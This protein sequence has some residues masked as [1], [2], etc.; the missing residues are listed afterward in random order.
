M[1]DT[2]LTKKNRKEMIDFLEKIK[3]SN[4]DDETLK[5]V[6]R[7]EKEL[8]EKKF[9][10][11]FEE[12][13]EEVDDLLQTNIPVLCEDAQRRICKDENLPWNFIIEW[14]N[15]QALYLLLKTHR[16]K[17]DCIYIDPPYNTWARDWKYNNDYVDNNDWYRHSKWLSMMKV[18][19]ELAK[20][21]LNPETWVL[22]ATIDEHEVHRLRSLLEEIFPEAAIQMVTIVMNPKWVTQGRFSRVEEYA[23]YV[24]MPKAFPCK[25]TDSM[26]I[27]DNIS[28]KV[29]WAWLIRSGS[30]AARADRPKMYYPILI[31]KNL[32]K[33]IKWWNILPLEKHPTY[34]ENIDGY[35]VAW[36]VRTDN[37]E[38]HWSVNA[39]TFNKLV[40]LG[41][42]SLGKYDKKR[43]TWGI[44]YL[45][46]K[47]RKQIESGEIEIT[48][49]DSNN[50]VSV[51][52]VGDKFQEIRTVR[53]RSRL[54]AWTY[55]SDLI[56]K[57]LCWKRFSYPKSL[58][59]VVDSIWMIVWDN[60]NATILD[61]FAGS[62]TTQHAVN[63]LNAK[64]NGNRKCIMVTNNEISE[65]EEKELTKKW[66]KK[67]DEEWEKLWIAKYVTWPRTKCSIEWVDVKGKPLEWNYWM[68]K[69]FYSLNNDIVA[70]SKENE[71]EIKGNFYEKE[72]IQI[73][74]E[75]SNL[76]QSTW[77]KTNIKY[78][79][80]DWTP[81]K[82]E[83]YFLSNVLMLH[84]KEMIEL[85]NAIEIDNSKNVLILNKDDYTKY[86]E[87]ESIYK[88]I[89]NIRV[90]QKIVFD[91]KEIEK[92]KKKNFKY[93]PVEYFWQ[94]LKDVAE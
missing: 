39:E 69:E 56:K 82:P 4:N 80:C 81:R 89:E 49:R 37:S 41:Y 61:F 21:L 79:K 31:D 84:I 20:Q 22:I 94:E 55:G 74:P 93:I 33:V 14:D 7:I 25:W 30:N 19:L 24:F 8:T 3:S 47:V 77:F 75:F 68:E 57:I 11:V 73:Y 58:Y 65:D 87:N 10:L 38:W 66:Y 64:D 44:S 13:R 70:Y 71:E 59:A 12:H 54:N 92:M 5:M 35:D 46:D 15:L 72:T 34:K 52:Y 2:N 6:N 42:V 83:E 78:F 16:W 60:K 48:G 23:I 50:V 18:R 43:K 53:Y 17:I 29:R 36:P 90:N 63:L 85:E 51:R 9:W 40:K 45:S 32:K 86:I 1:T 28:D 88:G 67:W 26:L 62:W 76:K 91:P 27:E